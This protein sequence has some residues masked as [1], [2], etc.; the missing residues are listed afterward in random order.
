[1][2]SRDPLELALG[3]I[4]RAIDDRER[5]A[6]EWLVRVESEDVQEV[7]REC[8]G[9]EGGRHGCWAF[10]GRERWVER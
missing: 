4:P 8:V 1:M 9:R 10:V 7:V 6:G 5:V 2:S 3:E